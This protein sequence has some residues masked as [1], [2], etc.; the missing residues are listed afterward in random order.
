[1]SLHT[2][3]NCTIQG[4]GATGNFETADCYE[5]VNG[6]SGCGFGANDANNPNNYGSQ[7][8]SVGGGVYMTEWTS[9]YI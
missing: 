7:L 8:N 2:S 9:Q 1:M 6:N 3:D 5:A 4:S